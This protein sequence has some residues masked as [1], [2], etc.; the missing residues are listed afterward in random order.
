MAQV[1]VRFFA[2]Y[3]ELTGCETASVAIAAAETVGDVVN[4]IRATIPGAHDLPTRPLAA[5]N[6]R[7][8]KLDAE[9]RDGDEVA[10][11]PPLS[12]G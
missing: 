1:T 11:L 12:G 5:L 3:A 2:R 4:R 8:V 6:Q 9:V 7:Q 10:L